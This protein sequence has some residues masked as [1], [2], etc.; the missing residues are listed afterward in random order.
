[1]SD[2]AFRMMPLAR[3]YRFHRFP[4]LREI[5]T[6][7][8][9]ARFRERAVD[10]SLVHAGAGA[11][12]AWL[13]D[14][15]VK[16]RFGTSENAFDVLDLF[17]FIPSVDALLYAPD[18]PF[19]GAYFRRIKEDDPLRPDFVDYPLPLPR[20]KIVYEKLLDRAGEA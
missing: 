10:G 20:G 19:E 3:L 5:Y 18:L 13:S 16:K 12:G 17:S 6:T 2:R 14:R 1:V 11:V 8:A 9:E 7:L 4:L 15:Y